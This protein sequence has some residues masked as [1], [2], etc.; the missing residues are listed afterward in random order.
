MTRNRFWLGLGLLSLTALST[1]CNKEGGKEAPASP[2]A[3]AA[4]AP[5]AAAPPSTAVAPEPAR[6]QMSHAKLVA[7]FRPSATQAA[8]A[9][10]DSPERIALGKML[11]FENR[12]SKNHDI[13]CNSCHDLSAFG[14]DGKAT[15]Q[16]H[17]GQKGSRNSPT[18]FHAAGHVAQFWDGRAATL[19]DQAAGPMM[20]PAEMAMPDEKLVLATLNSIHQY[21]KAFKTAYPEDKK[22]VSITNAARS[23]AA[24]ERELLTKARFD[25]YLA[26]D[27]Q[28]LSD[29]E[30]RGLNLFAS[31]GC[32]TCHNGP[33]VGGTSFQKLG[34]IEDYPTEDKGR[35]GVTKNE[36]DMHKFRVPTLRN[37][38]K[39]GPWFHDGS[40]KELSTAV[41]LMGRHQLGMTFTD[42]EVE[43]I[44]AF[45]KSLT[46]DL[47]GPE[48]T[49]APELP[50]STATTPKPDPT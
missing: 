15:S 10:K 46:G 50:P 30:R 37:V 32:T 35:F 19:E 23:I 45:L 41:R 42:A 47:P 44:V 17:K 26:G 2:S 18:V 4:A 22:P 49:Q 16:G 12:L 14:V 38:E 7:F 3:P 6:P 8:T 31:S 21:V 13:S 43:D 20:N 29:Q 1:S 36:E 39:T 33:S 28:A 24:F 5:A 48:L 34:L 40:V 27:E 25:K 11:F 9:R